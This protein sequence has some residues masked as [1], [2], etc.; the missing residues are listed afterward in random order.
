MT[1]VRPIVVSKEP[2]ANA[3]L[4]PLPNGKLFELKGERKT[5]KWVKDGIVRRFAGEHF[6]INRN[7]GRAEE[8]FRN[9]Q[10]RAIHAHFG[11]NGYAILPVAKQL[12]IPLITNFY[13]SDTAPNSTDD[14]WP[15]QRRI[16]F[17]EGDLFLVEGAHM[18]RRLIDLGCSPEK[19]QIQ[20]IAI[21]FDKLKARA[22][23][24]RHPEPVVLFAGRFVEKKGLIYSLQAI[25]RLTGAG[26]KLTFRIIGDGPTGDECRAYVR[27]NGL[28]KVVQFLGFLNH[29]QYLAE[30][31]QANIF[32]HPSVTAA[33]GD[34]EGGAPT[35][36]LEA[37]ACCVPIVSTRHADIPNVVAVDESAV[38]AHERDVEGLASALASV[39]DHP[40]RWDQ[41][42]LAGRAFVEKYH[43][44]SNEVKLLE[45]KYFS[46]IK[47]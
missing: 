25:K 31:Q 4:F 44:V 6:V 36:I 38:L 2:L 15:E 17:R 3:H 1:K 28:E 34:T 16:L 24:P 43:D 14:N 27:E 23:A 37:Q 39:L 7:L 26:Y 8:I 19:V 35:T 18:R 46:L 11:P 41:M 12:G 45:D 5:W 20:H 32:L 42:G 29:D 33:N 22:S 30:L 40:G 21:R 10:C 13:G 47:T 9:E